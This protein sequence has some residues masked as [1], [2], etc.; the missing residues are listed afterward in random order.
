MFIGAWAWESCTPSFW[1][2]HRPLMSFHPSPSDATSSSTSNP[3]SIGYFKEHEEGCR[4]FSTTDGG[5]VRG[6]ANNSV[7]VLKVA[8]SSGRKSWIRLVR[9]DFTMRVTVTVKIKD[10][11]RRNDPQ[12]TRSVLQSEIF[13]ESS[14]LSIEVLRSYSSLKEFWGRAFDL[15]VYVKNAWCKSKV[16]SVLRA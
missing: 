9:H 11:R 16:S 15:I 13:C 12:R 7:P 1:V 5:T 8:Q 2:T 10:V 6:I 14:A 3:F 4:R